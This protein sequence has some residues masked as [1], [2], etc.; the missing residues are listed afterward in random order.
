MR[1]EYMFQAKKEPSGASSVEMTREG[2]F[3]CAAVGASEIEAFEMLIRT[4][5]DTNQSAG[6]IESAQRAL[7][8]RHQS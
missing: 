7:V 2:R 6:A 3:V 8:R 4:L 5:R 1:D